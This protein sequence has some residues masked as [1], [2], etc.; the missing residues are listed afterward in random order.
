MAASAP[1]PAGL[2]EVPT[3]ADRGYRYWR[4]LA[5]GRGLAGGYRDRAPAEEVGYQT[6]PTTR[7][8]GHLGAHLRGLGVEA[9]VTRRWA[10]IMGFTADELPIVGPLPARPRPSAS[11]RQYR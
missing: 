7:V 11:C 2:V 5:D 10:G 6:V 9:P 3:S 8:Q 1:A 4:Q